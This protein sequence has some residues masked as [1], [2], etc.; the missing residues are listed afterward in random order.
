MPEQRRPH[1][2]GLRRSRESLCAPVTSEFAGDE[3]GNHDT[4]G[5]RQHSGHTQ[6]DQ[7]TGRHGIR[8]CGQRRGQG[9]LIGR[10]PVKVMAADGKHVNLIEPIPAE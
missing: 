2:R 4:A 8:Q 6:R 3:A 1:T 5:G 9:W 7:R 10:S